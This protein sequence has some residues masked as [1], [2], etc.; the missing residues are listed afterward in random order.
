MK[1]KPSTN[2]LAAYGALG[3]ALGLAAVFILF[4]IFT[5]PRVGSGMDW[6]HA[7]LAWIGVGGIVVVLIVVHL[8]FARLLLRAAQEENGVQ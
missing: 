6:T 1:T 3:V 7:Q 8:V 2:R 5:I 4:V